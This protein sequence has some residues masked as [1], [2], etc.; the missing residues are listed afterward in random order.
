MIFELAS[1]VLALQGLANPQLSAIQPT[2]A[3]YKTLLLQ[4]AGNLESDAAGVRNR[5]RHLTVT[6]LQ[7]YFNLAVESEAE[8]VVAPE[9]SV[10]WDV[11]EN[12]IRNGV[13]LSVVK[14]FGTVESVI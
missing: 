4:P 12:A 5:D 11:L 7:S 2:I 9:Y 13:Y 10:P 8:L 1:D 14:T 6:Q 3:T